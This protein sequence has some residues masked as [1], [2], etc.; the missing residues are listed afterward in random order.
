MLD[1]DP[2]SMIVTIFAESMG[3]HEVAIR[4]GIVL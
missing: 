1:D 4:K 2:K 3:H